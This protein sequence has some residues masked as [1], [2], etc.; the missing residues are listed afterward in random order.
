MNFLVLSETLLKRTQSRCPV[1]HVD[2]PA[3]VW[4]VGDARRQRV[5]LRRRCPE[6]GEA[7]A[8]IASD[9]R[10]YWLAQGEPENACCG[11]NACAASDGAVRGTLGRNAAGGGTMEDGESK[12]RILNQ[13]FS[14]LH[15]RTSLTPPRM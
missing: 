11:G 2:C 15:P 10:F 8:C 1:C 12:W 7:E 5:M 13:L 9:A 4:K 14:I 6:H 3:E